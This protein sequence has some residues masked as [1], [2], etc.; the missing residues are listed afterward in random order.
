M[1]ATLPAPSYR[2][3]PATHENGPTSALGRRC[4]SALTACGTSSPTEVKATRRTRTSRIPSVYRPPP[5]HLRQPLVPP[6][7]VP[8]EL[9]PHGVLLV[10]VLVVVL[11]GPERRCRPDLGPHARLQHRLR[12]P[13][14]REREPLLLGVVGEDGRPVLLP[15]VAEL[16]VRRQRVDVVP[17]D[18]QQLLVR[19][20][21]RVVQHLH[22]L[23]VAG[24]AGRH[25]L[26]RR[27]LAVAAGVA[28]S[29]G[30]NAVQALERRLHAPEAAAG[31]RRLC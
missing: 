26:V 6:A 9:V 23:C 2:Y 18:V 1:A 21:A 13:L 7:V 28:G 14:R 31:E 11:G 4:S 25:L 20:L 22:R 5:P 19:H 3:G 30:V 24:E 12:L 29:H 8:V 27:V 16:R 10:V 15:V 17:V